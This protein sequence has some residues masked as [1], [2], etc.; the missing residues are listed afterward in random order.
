MGTGFSREHLIT[1]LGRADRRVEM[2]QSIAADY[3]PVNAR[4]VRVPNAAAFRVGDRVLVQR[5]GTAAWIKKLGMET[6]GGGV[7]AL[8]W[9]PGQRE[10]SWDRQVMA[11]DANGLT[12]DAPLTT[13]LDKTYGGGTVARYT[14]PGRISEVGIENLRLE[15]TFDA[16]N[17]KDEA[18]RWMAIV[19][20]N[21]QDAWV[22]QVAFRH[23]AG[24]AVLAHATVRRLTVEDCKSTEPVSEIGNERRNTFYTLGTQTLFQRL[25]AEQ[26]YHDFA[27][28]YCAPG[29]NAFVQCE[30]EQAL[31][32]SGGIDS[33]ASGVL[34]DIVK[35]YGQALRFGNRE[36]DGQ[37]A[38]WAVANSVFWQCT[39]AR[40]DC[41]QPPT[42][43]N[44]AF[45]H[46]GAVRRQWLLGPVQRKHQP[47][48]PLLRATERPAGRGHQ[49][50]RHPA[51]RA[52]RGLQQPQ[53][54]RG[55]GAYQALGE[56]RPHPDG[57]HRRRPRPPA[58]F[59][60]KRGP[61]H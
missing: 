61:D 42:A 35:E 36:Q 26:G 58:D 8:G 60:S 12:L 31:S 50:P 2:P 52:V 43:Q 14:W 49:S 5:P 48:Q 20:E 51:A 37:G 11:V 39:A 9:K 7:S 22:R 47:T 53:S 55:P 38:G 3:V 25:Y 34:F 23:F 17:P 16:A 59:Y 56:P 32:F 41:Y 28:G 27:V 19:L 24:S 54:C 4:T 10:I 45:R 15:S 1:V 30:A 18:H 46:L 29:P 21:V 44:W 33:W 13:A 40:V 6:F 57:A